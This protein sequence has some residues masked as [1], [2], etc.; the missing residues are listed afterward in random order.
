MAENLHIHF[1][2]NEYC[3]KFMA[4]ML[5]YWLWMNVQWSCSSLLSCFILRWRYI[6]Y[7]LLSIGNS[8]RGVVG[9]LK[10]LSIARMVG[11]FVN[12]LEG[13]DHGLIKALS[14]HC[15]MGLRKTTK[16]SVRIAGTLAEIQT[17]HIWNTSLECYRYASWFDNCKLKTIFFAGFVLHW[18]LYTLIFCILLCIL[19]LRH[20][21]GRQ[22]NN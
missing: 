3:N 16:K 15:L 22:H 9:Y 8:G 21:S 17:K 10:T 19:Y 11:W 20:F 6:P 7:A 14:W 5:F 2:K 13:N 12:D 1:M 4:K 18:K